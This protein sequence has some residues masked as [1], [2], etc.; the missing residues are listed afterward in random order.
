MTVEVKFPSPGEFDWSPSQDST[1]INDGTEAAIDLNLYYDIPFAHFAKNERLGRIAEWSSA[2]GVESHGGRRIHS[3]YNPSGNTHVANEENSGWT[4]T[5]SNDGMQSKNKRTPVPLPGKP[6]YSSSTRMGQSSGKYN[7]RRGA[8]WGARYNDKQSQQKREASIDVKP[9]WQMLDEIEFSRLSKLQLDPEDPV[10]LGSHG[11]AKV[12]DRSCDKITARTERALPHAG[13]ST[14][15]IH[16]L[17]S[18]EDDVLARNLALKSNCNVLVSD[19]VASMLMSC[20]RTVLPWDVVVKKR[21]NCLIFDKRP[22]SDIDLVYVNENSLEVNKE[23][24]DESFNSPKALA[25]EATRISQ[26]LSSVVSKKETVSLSER[27]SSMDSTPIRYTKVILGDEVQVLVRGQICA[28]KD[29]DLKNSPISLV[30]LLQYDQKCS[31]SMDWRL[32]LDTQGGAILAQEIHNNHSLLSK[33]V[34]KA[35]LLGIDIIKVAYVSRVSSRDRSRHSLLG[36]QE[37]EPYEL[38]SQMNLNVPNGFGILRAVVDLCKDL[39][40]GE[41]LVLMRDPNK[42]MLRLYEMRSATARGDAEDPIED[43]IPAVATVD[44]SDHSGSDFSGQEI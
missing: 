10:E 7:G 30:S 1:Q 43:L 42:P 14:E 12:Y 38:A 39:P 27:P 4:F 41:N 35:L 6:S 24:S 33:A 3:R 8:G 5:A 25:L 37:Y 22:E 15:P 34:F 32:K 21:D 26:V 16:R 11:T 19:V 44:L 31:N 29:T 28:L 18:L 17:T 13:P 20:Q 36:L 23:G 40:S 9:E 2:G